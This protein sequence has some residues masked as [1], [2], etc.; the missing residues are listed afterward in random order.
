MMKFALA[1]Y[2][3]K[4]A[5]VTA[6]AL[7]ALIPAHADTTINN[8]G[9]STVQ[10]WGITNTATYGQTVL[11]PAGENFLTSFTF[12]FDSGPDSQTPFRA[13]VFS[14]N[15]VN[16]ATGSSRFTSGIL[17]APATFPSAVTVN[18]GFV[19]VTPGET[20]VLFFSTSGLQAGQP[21]A[22]YIWSSSP[23][24]NYADGD[25]V[26]INNGDD[27][28][29]WT[30][31]TWDVGFGSAPDLRFTA[32]FVSGRGGV[33]APEPASLLLLGF[34]APFVARLRRR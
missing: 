16:A 13:H 3:G 4:A 9:N 25:F 15:G 26:F 14:W 20:I 24:N 10:P 11:V 19:P 30:G 34:V 28:S 18:T 33:A 5:L 29:Q 32:T 27:T 21:D 23:T 7:S 31:G 17:N 12:T 6:L 22:G 1:S 2:L 8:P